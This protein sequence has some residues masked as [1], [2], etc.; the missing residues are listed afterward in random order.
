MACS[1]RPAAR[2]DARGGPAGGGAPRARQVR[3]RRR[4]DGV[5]GL[6][7]AAARKRVTRSGARPPGEAQAVMPVQLSAHELLGTGCCGRR[8]VRAAMPPGV[9]HMRYPNPI[10]YID[11]TICAEPCAAARFTAAGAA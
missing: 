1:P 7:G 10:P 4:G 2:A 5:Q 3:R 9:D 11:T 8:G 6:H